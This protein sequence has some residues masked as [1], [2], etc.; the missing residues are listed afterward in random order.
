[1]SDLQRDHRR[2][3]DLLGPYVL[4][5][6]SPKE[7]REVEE[8]LP[9]CDICQEEE[10]D[11]REAHEYMS[12]LA[13]VAG[14]PPQ[15]LKQ[16]ITS[17]LN[18]RKP[19]VAWLV[20]AAASL[21]LLITLAVA[22]S[23]GFFSPTATAASLKPTQLAP[24][25]TGDLQVAHSDTNIRA[26]LEVRDMPQLHENEYYELWFGKENG[27]VSAGTFTVD[28][29]GHCTLETNVPARTVGNYE[30]VG[31]TLEKFPKEPSMDDARVVLGGDLGG[32]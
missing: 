5:A 14:N 23:S 18:K 6:L 29:K 13:N 12:D 20:T 32:V 3:R 28:E 8:H 19:R 10:R 25:A 16:N 21:F 24:G 4:G 15:E 26:K 22:Y 27:R 9:H 11:L 17:D 1:M 7:E 2:I 30:R 31:I